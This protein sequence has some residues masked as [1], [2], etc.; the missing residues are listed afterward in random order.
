MGDVPSTTAVVAYEQQLAVFRD[1][2]LPTLE[3]IAWF[4]GTCESPRY[5][6]LVDG[7]G[8]GQPAD[9]EFACIPDSIRFETAGGEAIFAFLAGGTP[10]V[11]HDVAAATSGWRGLGGVLDEDGAAAAA[12][13]TL[14]GVDAD[15]I[16]LVVWIT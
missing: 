11:A 15:P 4:G 6:F 14:R 16:P 9:V 7:R 12:F 1:V 8:I 5:C 13:E 2:V 3:V 10:P